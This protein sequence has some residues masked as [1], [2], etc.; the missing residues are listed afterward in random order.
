VFENKKITVLFR[1]S[2]DEWDQNGPV[3]GCWIHLWRI[4]LPW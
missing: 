1:G 4:F 2:N 3:L